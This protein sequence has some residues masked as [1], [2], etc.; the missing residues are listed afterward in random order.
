MDGTGRGRGMEMRALLAVLALLL[1]IIVATPVDH[2]ESQYVAAV[3][4]MRD[5]LPYR[6]FAY[7]Q[8]PLQPLLFA[9]FGLLP[10]GWLVAGLRL[11]NAVCALGTLGIVAATLRRHGAGARTIGL[12]CGLMLASDVFLFA[13]TV[14]R[15]DALPMLLFTGG[16]A[17]ALRLAERDGGGRGAAALGGL[18][19]GA[20]ISAKISYALPAAAVGAALLMLRLLPVPCLVA[21]VFGGMLGLS[22]T[23]VLAGLAPQAAWFGIIDYSLIAP[24]QWQ[25]LLGQPEMLS[26]PVKL[27][28]LLSFA[29]LGAPLLALVL[30]AMA[31]RRE[32]LAA[33]T[34]MGRRAW[35]L[36][37]A[38]LGGLLAA[39]LPDPSY[40][41]Y[42]VPVLPPLFLR[43]GLIRWPTHRGWRIAAGLSAVAGLA[44]TGI[45]LATA[46]VAGSPLLAVI[47]DAAAIGQATGGGAVATL[48]PE[49][50]V[51]AGVTIDRRFIAGPFLF[52]MMP[53]AAG[54]IPAAWDA[55]GAGRVDAAFAAVPP[56]ALL[57]GT[58]RRPFRGHPGGLDAVLEDWARRHG[59]RPRPLV[60]RGVTLWLPAQR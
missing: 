58:E 21:I 15:N 37:A 4:A 1:A 43:L 26:A 23:L 29:V 13:G 20:A 25:R 49:R 35:L 19:M 11:A 39:Y 12:A 59:W 32:G 8:T 28:R 3:A 36:D 9:P 48:A 33:D 38:I 22:P 54:H 42:L 60:S 18:L 7:L 34:A 44:P 40:R 55:V 16:L 51:G 6:D 5:G 24:H 50:V 45:A 46:V 52:R 2:D 10:P 30:A 57:T 17:G 53:P 14:A 41:Q 47:R 56:A 27:L 31:R